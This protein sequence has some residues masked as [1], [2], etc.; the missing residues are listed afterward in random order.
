M[1]LG[2][3]GLI[4]LG[5]V[6]GSALTE[7]EKEKEIEKKLA[8]EKKLIEEEQLCDE[9]IKDRFYQML[10]H[11]QREIFI[12]SPWV[13]E[14]VTK[15]ILPTLKKAATRGVKIYIIY[16]I[17]NNYSSEDKRNQISKEQIQQYQRELGNAL[18]VKKDNTH[19]KICICD[20]SYLVGS[21]NFLSFDGEYTTNTWHELCSYGK[22]VK[23]IQEWKQTFFNIY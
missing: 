11:A 23:K 19:V 7:T 21:Y 15:Q 4:V 9:Q 13:S 12:I 17:A 2:T 1:I 5:A 16:G 6:L 3:L 20:D 18:T 8:T 10:S 14:R 22:N